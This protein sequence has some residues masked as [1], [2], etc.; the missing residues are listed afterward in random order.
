VIGAELLGERDAVDVSAAVA[1]GDRVDVEEEDQR[2][3]QPDVDQGADE[4]LDAF[5]TPVE[6]AEGDVGQED[7]REKLQGKKAERQWRAADYSA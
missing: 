4:H 1:V 6:A 5:A 3:E 7:K 2:H